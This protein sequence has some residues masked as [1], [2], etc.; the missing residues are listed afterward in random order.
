MFI[1]CTLLFV[2]YVQLLV[3]KN[4]YLFVLLKYFFRVAETNY[5]VLKNTF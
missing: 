2:C 4:N 1:R 5:L 3:R